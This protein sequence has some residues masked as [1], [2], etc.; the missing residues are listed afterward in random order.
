MRSPWWLSTRRSSPAMR[1]QAEEFCQA[2]GARA[3]RTTSRPGEVR[4]RGNC[5]QGLADPLGAR[6][7]PPVGALYR[8][9]AFSSV[10]FIQS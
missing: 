1:S 5:W 10:V 9:K 3:V 4:G 8:Y 7:R 6:A 2:A